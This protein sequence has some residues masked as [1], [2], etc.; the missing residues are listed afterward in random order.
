MRPARRGRSRRTPARRCRRRQPAPRYR[1][2]APR[3]RPRPRS[4]ILFIMTISS[5]NAVKK[6]TLPTVPVKVPPG[7][8]ICQGCVRDAGLSRRTASLGWPGEPRAAPGRAGRAGRRHPLPDPAAAGRG[9]RGR[10]AVPLPRAGR[11]RPGAGH[12]LAVGHRGAARAAKPARCWPPCASCARIRHRPDRP[13]GHRPAGPGRRARHRPGAARP[14]GAGRRSA[15]HRRLEVVLDAQT[16][17]AGWYRRFGFEPAGAEF[18]E[19]GIS[20]LPMRRPPARSHRSGTPTGRS[21]R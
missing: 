16:P 8:G 9:V 1:R 11:P 18:V 12:P 3:P 15:D 20:H 4:T 14:A 17:L 21:A 10:A 13:G 5:S 19:D 6:W 2:R 7:Q